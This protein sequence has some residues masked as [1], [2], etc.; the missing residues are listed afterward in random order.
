MKGL[1][2][3]NSGIMTMADLCL[4]CGT[5]CIDIGRTRKGYTHPFCPKGCSM[6]KKDREDRLRE[7]ASHLM[8]IGDE[9]SAA[10]ILAG[11]A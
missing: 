2:T 7:L 9:K 8:T 6:R 5:E 3:G 4:I 11:L 10:R 1:A